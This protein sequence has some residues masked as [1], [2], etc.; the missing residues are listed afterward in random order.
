MIIPCS[1]EIL[2]CLP[3]TAPMLR[4]VES[5]LEKKKCKRCRK[6]KILSD[7]YAKCG[8]MI[9]EQA[10][11]KICELSIIA[12]EL[13]G[14]DRHNRQEL[15][16]RETCMQCVVKHLSSAYAVC[17]EVSNGHPELIDCVINDIKVATRLSGDKEELVKIQ[18]RFEEVRYKYSIYH[19]K[20][21]MC[22]LFLYLSD[23]TSADR[24]KVIGELVQ[25]EE[26]SWMKNRELSLSIRSERI[27]FMDGEIGHAELFASLR[28]LLS[29]Q[30]I[31]VPNAKADSGNIPSP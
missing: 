30:P 29:A 12:L 3:S 28:I 18:E 31:M 15:I 20:I 21:A 6:K 9:F 11:D 10:H 13:L 2:K 19:L 23:V 17:S 27:K 22:Q 5:I 16:V 26:E 14:L 1:D 24:F 25:A 8:A 4:E 7:L